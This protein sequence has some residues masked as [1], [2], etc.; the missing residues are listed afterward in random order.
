MEPSSTVM[1]TSCSLTSSLINSPSRGLQNRAS[2]TVTEMPWSPRS[3]AAAKQFW[4]ILGGISAPM[5][6]PLGYLRQ[7]G[8]SSIIAAVAIMCMSSASSEGAITTMLG[9]QAM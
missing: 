1:R 4:I 2:A 8:R 9:R 3:L 6:F 5:P 7:L